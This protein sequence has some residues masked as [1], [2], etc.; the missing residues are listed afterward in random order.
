MLKPSNRSNLE[1]D[2]NS[3]LKRRPVLHNADST[4]L[5]QECT[6]GSKLEKYFKIGVDNSETKS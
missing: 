3:Q 6:H 4:I 1:A 5:N 2:V